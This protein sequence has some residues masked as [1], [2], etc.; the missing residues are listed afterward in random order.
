MKRLLIIAIL[1]LLA[2][3]TA[4]IFCRSTVVAVGAPSENFTTP[5]PPLSDNSTPE[6]KPPNYV[7]LNTTEQ[8]QT[9]SPSFNFDFSALLSTDRYTVTGNENWELYIDI[10]LPGW[11]YIYEFLPSEGNTAGR[12]IAYKWQL[13]QSGVWKIGPFTPETAEPEGK[14]LY[15]AW[16]YASGQWAKQDGQIPYKDISWSYIKKTPQ[17]TTENITL[18]AAVTTGE[19]ANDGFYRFITHPV[20]LLV[21]PSLLVLMFI[22]VRY[23]AAISRKPKPELA[24]AVPEVKQNKAIKPKDSYNKQAAPAAEAVKT[25]TTARAKLILPNGIELKLNVKSRVIG[26]AD[27]ARAMDTDKL[28]MI[29]RHHFEISFSGDSFFVEDKGSHNGTSLN[30]K[31]IT[32]QGP[33]ILTD[34]DIIEP[35]DAIPIIFQLY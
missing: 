2:L 17:Q 14:H 26:R 28:A 25:P 31:T 6:I 18:P 9:A 24:P 22:F 23:L 16:Y 7:F 11:V 19:K 10:N 1:I 12:W 15:R 35:A 34:N 8:N 33:V 29:S 5:E 27:V 4:T 20:V 21:A 13:Q 3:S 32:D 30:G